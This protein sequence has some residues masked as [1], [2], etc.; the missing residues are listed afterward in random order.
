MT[1]TATTMRALVQDG[2]GD[3]SVL[4]CA[5]VERPA[6]GDGQVLVRVHAAGVTRGVWHVMT[7]TPYAVRLAIG[8]RRPRQPVVGLELAGTVVATGAGVTRFAP[9]DEVFGTGP[10][11]FAEYAVAREGRLA[12]KP[13]SP[14][15]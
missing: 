8:L 13:T 14:Q 4:R 10:G 15:G 2:Y 5:Q 3:T 9:G 7:G 1:R 6:A 11:A 12:H